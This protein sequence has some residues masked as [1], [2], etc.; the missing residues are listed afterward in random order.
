MNKEVKQALELFIESIKCEIEDK[1]KN[2][3]D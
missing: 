1:K 2:E 3:K